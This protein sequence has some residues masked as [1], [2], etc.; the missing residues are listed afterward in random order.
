LFFQFNLSFHDN[1]LVIIS[2]AKLFTSF[3]Y[4]NFVFHI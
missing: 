3:F 2:A 4:D 1:H